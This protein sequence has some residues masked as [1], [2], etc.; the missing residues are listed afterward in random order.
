[1]K[2][3]IILF[4]LTLLTLAGCGPQQEEPAS[5]SQTD[6]SAVQTLYGS[7]A[8]VKKYHDQIT[9][10]IQT[11]NALHMNVYEAVGAS[12]AATGQNLARAITNLQVSAKTQSL[13]DELD[14]IQAP[15]LLA[16]LHRDIGKM[17]LLRLEWYDLILKGW[18]LEQE[19]QDDSL[20]AQAEV[21][22][23]ELNALGEKL[24]V[25][26]HEIYQALEQAIPPE[27]RTASP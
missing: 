1:M 14:Q 10:L 22:L 25:D 17:M 18:Q 13:I 23:R 26:L 3:L 27:Q 21:K 6:L 11:G 8:D 16:P 5:Q 24:N 9:P 7:A 4:L 20:Y 2:G 19:K 15:P 12:N